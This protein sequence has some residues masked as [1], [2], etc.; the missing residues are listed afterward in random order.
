M[1]RHAT[2][3][4]APDSFKGSLSSRQAAEAIAR[5]AAKALPEATL[6]LRRLADGGEGTAEAL[7]LGCG[8]KR[9]ETTAINPLGAPIEAEWFLDSATRTAFIDTAA[10]SGLTLLSPEQR[11]ATRT[12]T[13]GTGQ[14]IAEAMRQGA[15]RIILGLGGS[16]TMDLGYGALQAFGAEFSDETGHFLQERICGNTLPRIAA[17]HLPTSLADLL[18]RKEIICACDVTTPLCG[19]AGAAPVF[20]PQKG[21]NPDEIG[22]F[23]AS[24]ARQAA[25]LSRLCGHDIALLPRSGAAGGLGASLHALAGA[26]LTD[27]AQ[28]LIGSETFSR[29]IADAS[30]V[31]TGEGSADRQ[32]LMGKAP[33]ALM[34]LAAGADRPTI[35][36]AGKIS[37][38]DALL[39]AGFADAACIN[40]TAA[41]PQTPLNTGFSGPDDTESAMR[42]EVATPRLEEAARLAVSRF[43]AASGRPRHEKTRP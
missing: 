19:D 7:A 24:F 40:P 15:R 31:I 8:A 26:T 14:L 4:I 38:R 2:I 22:K 27:G 34:R 16:A 9:I 13:Y 3:L 36:L 35:L 21:L 23:S 17:I 39:Q 29:D 33:Y 12:S 43:F 6:L 18:A 41:D 1:N 42:P 20:G 11:D 28:L 10:A 5:G 25:L 30:L 32:T 37:D